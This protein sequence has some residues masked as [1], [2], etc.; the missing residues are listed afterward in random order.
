M[1]DT[2]DRLIRQPAGRHIRARGSAAAID[3]RGPDLIADHDTPPGPGGPLAGRAL[4]GGAETTDDP[5]SAATILNPAALRPASNLAG[6]S[7]PLPHE[8]LLSRRLPHLQSSLNHLKRPIKTHERIASRQPGQR[9]LC[10]V[11]AAW[12]ALVIA[13]AARTRVTPFLARRLPGAAATQAKWRAP[14]GPFVRPVPFVASRAG[15]VPGRHGQLCRRT[16]P[17]HSSATCRRSS[18]RPPW[19]PGFSVSLCGIPAPVRRWLS[20]RCPQCSS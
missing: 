5:D 2:A 13:R 18:A 15:A 11:L 4:P 20:T 14:R 10:S 9:R 16:W 19:L 12:P 8:C 1:L 3:Q 17:S 6:I 7:H